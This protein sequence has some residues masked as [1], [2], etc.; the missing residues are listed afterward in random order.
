MTTDPMN[1][2]MIQTT[3]TQWQSTAT[4]PMDQAQT[5]GFRG[6]SRIIEPDAPTLAQL[7]EAFDEVQRCRVNESYSKGVLSD[8]QAEFEADNEILIQSVKNTQDARFEAEA[9]ARALT[10]AAYEADPERKKDVLPGCLGIREVKDVGWNPE[11]ALAWALEHKVALK[12][13]EAA[14]KRLVQGSMA[15]GVVSTKVTATIASSP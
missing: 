2:G 10:I 9:H 11:Q 6:I 3:E 7:R 13:D 1:T 8:R 15:P 5:E 4:T 12:L 14:Y